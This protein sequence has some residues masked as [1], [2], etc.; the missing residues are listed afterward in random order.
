M[1]N[2]QEIQEEIEKLESCG[3]TTYAVCEKL[4]I[5]YNVKDHSAADRKPE[6]ASEVSFAGSEFMLAAQRVQQ[7]DLIQILDEHMEAIRLIFP[8]EYNA[9]LRK[10][11]AAR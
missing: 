1:L 11:D 3:A 7:S 8:K 6:R 4:A 10:L 2:M 9:V 5:L